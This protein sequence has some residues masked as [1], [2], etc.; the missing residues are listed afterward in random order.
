MIRFAKP[1]FRPGAGSVI[2][3]TTGS[4]LVFERADLPGTWQFQ[5]GGMDSGETP[6]ETLWRELR[7]ETGLRADDFYTALP[8]HR[9]TSYAYP[10]EVR[11]NFDKHCLG[12][13]HRWF[14]LHLKPDRQI[15]LTL[16]TDQE[17]TAWRWTD[18]ATIISETNEMKLPVYRELHEHFETTILPLLPQ[19]PEHTL[20]KTSH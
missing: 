17:F 14:F 8:Y 19:S 18:F 6:E 13:V 16:A 1:Y 5:Q 11:R 3:N 12:Q 7:E 2:Y 10:P 4:I 20:T 9:W 15:D